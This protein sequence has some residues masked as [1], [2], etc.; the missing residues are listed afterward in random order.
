MFDL[1]DKYE[2]LVH[3]KRALSDD[4]RA[5]FYREAPY[6]LLIGS[7]LDDIEPNAAPV[8]TVA[9]ARRVINISHT[10]APIQYLDHPGSYGRHLGFLMRYRMCGTNLSS[11][12]RVI[13]YIKHHMRTGSMFFYTSG[14][15]YVPEHGIALLN[16]RQVR[17][18]PDRR[19]TIVQLP[20]TSRINEK[21]MIDILKQGDEHRGEEEPPIKYETVIFSSGSLTYTVYCEG[22]LCIVGNFDMNITIVKSDFDGNYYIRLAL[23]INCMDSTVVYMGNIAIRN[24]K[25]HMCRST[26]DLHRAI[27][28]NQGTVVL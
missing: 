8:P 27:L 14:T 3:H 20:L 19:E 11:V 21:W 4:A 25:P 24:N 1:V 16:S 6:H 22:P 7:S 2:I 28:D 17:L 9:Q 13:S 5:Y 18:D 23:L 26:E 10:A 12:S 15:L